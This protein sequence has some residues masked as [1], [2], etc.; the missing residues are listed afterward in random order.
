MCETEGDVFLNSVDFPIID[1]NL[2]CIF[3]FKNMD[4]CS[5][6]SRVVLSQTVTKSAVVTNKRSKCTSNTNFVDSKAS[7]NKKGLCQC[8]KRLMSKTKKD[9]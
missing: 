9:F 7:T 3:I 6:V 1:K 5:R 4:T 2:Y 8:N